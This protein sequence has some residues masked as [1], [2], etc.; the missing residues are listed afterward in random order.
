M[1]FPA[2]EA[3]R[4]SQG[5]GDD[6][7]PTWSQSGNELLFHRLVDEGRSVS[8]YDPATRESREIV[9]AGENPM[10]ASLDPNGEYAVYAARVE[11]KDRLRI[12]ETGSGKKRDLRLELEENCEAAFPRWSPK[13]SR[14]A[15]ALKRGDRWD[16]AVTEARG[17][18]VKVLSAG[19]PNARGMRSMLDWSP[20]GRK[21]VFHASTAPFEANLYLA[22]VETGSVRNLT[23]DEWYSESP[24]FTPDGKGVTF[25]STRGG[26]WTWGFFKITIATGKVE[27]LLGP[28][29]IEKNYPRLNAEGTLLWSQLEPDGREML[30]MRRPGGEI[31][32]IR[33]SENWARWPSYSP[34]GKKILF[35]SVDH[36]VEYWLAENLHAA[37]SPLQTRPNAGA[38]QTS[39][40]S[41]PKA[42]GPNRSAQRASP[43]QMHHR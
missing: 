6:R 30:A 25:M 23:N 14:I 8:L 9:P 34:D 10:S 35:T 20:D 24:A 37:D 17:G 27:L 31:T 2:G 5:E 15:F 42:G 3:T 13:G 28:D 19:I 12:V 26:N 32:L 11:G 38:V 7:W 43:V 22:N 39:D 16:I 4:L 18:P 36:R 21:L 41:A 33:Q 40:A 29:Y 1:P